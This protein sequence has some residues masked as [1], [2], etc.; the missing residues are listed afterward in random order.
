MKLKFEVKKIKDVKAEAVVSVMFEDSA[1]SKLQWL[2]TLFKGS[3]DVLINSKDFKGNLNETIV[4]MSIAKQGQGTLLL[5]L[6][7]SKDNT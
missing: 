5:G 2:N 1:E 6:G 7:K 3:L 4:I